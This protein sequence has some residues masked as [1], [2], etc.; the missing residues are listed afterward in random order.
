MDADFSR[1]PT[2]EG[3]CAVLRPFHATDAAAMLRACSDPE[4][5]WL[6]GTVSS[7]EELNDLQL[8]EFEQWYG[9]RDM[10]DDRLDLAIVDRDSGNVVG[11]A[12]LNEWSAANY[13]ASMRVR[14]GPKGRDRG[15]GFETAWMLLDYAFLDLDLNRVSCTVYSFNKRAR[16][17]CSKL[18]MTHEGTDRQALLFDGYWVDRLR[19]GILQSE[20]RK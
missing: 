18:G 11:E 16:H 20:W 1:K 12:V 7:S 15:I 4:M 5:Q 10:A 2:L 19:L 9:T 8:G 3:E 14:I 13:S 17:L 6:T